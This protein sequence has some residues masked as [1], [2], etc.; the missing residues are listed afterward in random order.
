MVATSLVTTLPITSTEGNDTTATHATTTVSTT[1][2]VAVAVS[3]VAMAMVVHVLLGWHHALGTIV[4]TAAHIASRA[5]AHGREGTAETGCTAL[6][7]GEPTRR[8]GP[9]ARTR[10]VLARRERRQNLAST[11]QHTA[12]GGGDLNG[13]LVEST[14]VHAETFGGLFVGRKHGK[15]SARGLVLLGGAESPKG[16]RATAKLRE[17]ALELRLGSV[18]GQS[19]HVQ[20][21]TPLRQECTDV[22]ACIHRAR[23]NIGVLVSG[24]GL[25]DEPAKNAS[26]G[27]RLLHCSARR[28]RGEG[29][30]VEGQVVLDGGAG[31]DGLDLEGSTD[32]CEGRGAER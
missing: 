10:A 23:E 21:L 24:L 6:E 19:G 2:H 22:G 13:L 27:D 18:V 17:P 29:L 26:E 8:A 12:R 28:G 1:A 20:N 11:V 15:A 3:M 4:V 5:S 9:V 30:Q 32:V 14:A 31:L 25:A 16:N 7:V